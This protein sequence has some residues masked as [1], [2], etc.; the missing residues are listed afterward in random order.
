[1]KKLNACVLLYEKELSTYQGFI[2][3]K[4]GSENG[5][6]TKIG[7]FKTDPSQKSETLKRILNLKL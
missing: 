1:M 6:F 7:D 3:E 2:Q 4:I 5:P